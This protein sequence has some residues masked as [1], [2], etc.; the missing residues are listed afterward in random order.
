MKVEF[1]AHS[2]DYGLLRLIPENSTDQETLN[3]LYKQHF[4]V[5][6]SSEDDLF[7]YMEVRVQH[8]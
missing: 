1:R 6:Y 3:Q 7:Q 5:S 8:P 4:D 2:A